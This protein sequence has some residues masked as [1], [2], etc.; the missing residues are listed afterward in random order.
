MTV[1]FYPS[2]IG[3]YVNLY[4]SIKD[5]VFGCINLCLAIGAISALKG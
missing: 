2:D 1:E 4:V 3:K 5:W